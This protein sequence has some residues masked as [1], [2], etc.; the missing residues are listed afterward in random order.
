M[1]PQRGAMR[2]YRAP[3]AACS[4]PSGHR[5]RSE[6]NRAVS[7]PPERGTAKDMGISL[8][9]TEEGDGA[10]VVFWKNKKPFFIV[11]LF[12][13]WALG[14]ANSNKYNSIQVGPVMLI[15]GLPK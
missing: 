9:K 15:K 10:G 13:K 3:R 2:A 6:P 14:I 5:F 4:E 12:D 11:A 7:E 1:R 8:I